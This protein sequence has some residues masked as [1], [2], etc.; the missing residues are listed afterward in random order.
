LRAPASGREVVLALDEPPD[1]TERAY[2]DRVTGERLEV[3]SMLVPLASSPSN[4][5]RSPETVRICPHCGELVE[6]DLSDCPYC[7]RRMPALGSNDD[8]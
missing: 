4:L 8:K 7:Q 6:I 5:P 1:G 3:V 2:Y